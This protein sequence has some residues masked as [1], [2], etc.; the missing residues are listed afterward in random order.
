MIIVMAGML[1]LGRIKASWY[2]ERVRL[3]ASMCT[4]VRMARESIAY[5][6]LPPDGIVAAASGRQ[7]MKNVAFLRELAA[8]DIASEG[9]LTP[10]SKALSSLPL[11][12]DE[13]ALLLSWGA[14]LGKSDRDSQIFSCDGALCAL[15]KFKND[16]AAEASKQGRMWTS[17][18][19]IGGVFAVIMLV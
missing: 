4:F 13:R 5:L 16:A 15:E 11:N 1:F 8:S 12:E 14:V 7:D 3:L 6:S 19:A 10:W 2:E 18:G 17:L 9:F